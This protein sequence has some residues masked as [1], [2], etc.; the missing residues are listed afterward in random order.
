MLPVCI[1]L[2]L[3]TIVAP[4]Q[5]Q[6]VA[7]AQNSNSESPTRNLDPSVFLKEGARL[8]NMV[9]F[10]MRKATPFGWGVGRLHRFVNMGAGYSTVAPEGGAQWDILTS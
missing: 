4:R 7:G 8:I 1:R 9:S 2:T 10:D 3:S 5:P 6:V